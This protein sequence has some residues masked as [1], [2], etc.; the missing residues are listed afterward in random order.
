MIILIGVILI[1]LSI[2]LLHQNNKEQY[3]YQFYCNTNCADVC[4]R[5]APKYGFSGSNA[6]FDCE[7]ACNNWTSGNA[8]DSPCKGPGG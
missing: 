3:Q 4:E 1:I 5:L 6:L 8:N 7:I 2:L